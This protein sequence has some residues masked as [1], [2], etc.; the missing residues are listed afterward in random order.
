VP[1]ARAI[2]RLLW[3]SGSSP[4]VLVVLTAKS[5][6]NARQRLRAKFGSRAWGRYRYRPLSTAGREALV[7][8][9]ADN[10]QSSDPSPRNSASFSR[11]NAPFSASVVGRWCS[12]T[13]LFSW[14]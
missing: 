13:Q 1:G 14:S 5:A 7:T 2:T 6:A 3:I 4:R 9:V 10:S 11:T 8:D 12:S